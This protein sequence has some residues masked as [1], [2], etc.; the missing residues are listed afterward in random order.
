MP[1]I[2]AGTKKLFLNLIARRP[3]EDVLE[4]SPPLVMNGQVHGLPAADVFRRFKKQ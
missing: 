1:V 2:L 4:R 3:D